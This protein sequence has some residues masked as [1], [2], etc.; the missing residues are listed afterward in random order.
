MEADL[1]DKVNEA[2]QQK[3]RRVILPVNNLSGVDKIVWSVWDYI[4]GP[5]LKFVWEIVASNTISCAN[6][7]DEN[8]SSISVADSSFDEISSVDENKSPFAPDPQLEPGKQNFLL[9]TDVASASGD[10]MESSQSTLAESESDLV[11]PFSGLKLNPQSE[12]EYKSNLE[13]FEPSPASVPLSQRLSFGLIDDEEKIRNDSQAPNPDT[14]LADDRSDRSQCTDDAGAN[15]DNNYVAVHTLSSEIYRSHFGDNL[16]FKLICVPERHLTVAAY[17]FAAR[18]KN[19]KARHSIS[20]LMNDKRLKWFLKI[21]NFCR[22]YFDDL[23]PRLKAAALIVS[24][25]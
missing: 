19:A 23:V 18:H 25:K 2:L 1:Y 20:L 15:S 7:D 5:E 22:S 6:S 14:I 10:F 16:D 11:S 21:K 24:N 13:I 12:S 9:S 17:V 3:S 8:R 4:M